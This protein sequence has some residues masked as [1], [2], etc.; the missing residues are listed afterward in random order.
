MAL[1]SSRGR[2]TRAAGWFDD[3][4]KDRGNARMKSVILLDG[5]KGWVLAGEAYESY[6]EGFAPDVWQK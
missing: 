4:I 5:V 3:L 6:M 2:G 1:G